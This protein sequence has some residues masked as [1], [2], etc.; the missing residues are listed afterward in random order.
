MVCA[1][2]SGLP[3]FNPMKLLHGEHRLTLLRPLQPDVKVKS[4]TVIMDVLDK[5]VSLG[6]T[7]GEHRLHIPHF[8][9]YVLGFMMDG[10]RLL[11]IAFAVGGPRG[12]PGGDILRGRAA[13]H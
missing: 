10:R 7:R 2:F 13:L 12:S 1:F 3:P 6:G 8:M 5:K 9:G 4:R 11:F